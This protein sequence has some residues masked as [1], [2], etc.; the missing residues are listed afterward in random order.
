MLIDA[1]RGER[2]IEDEYE[3]VL[4]KTAGSPVNQLL[5]RHLEGIKASRR[6]IERLKEM[7]A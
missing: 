5:Q 2:A 1:E 4:I 3:D 7:T 6:R